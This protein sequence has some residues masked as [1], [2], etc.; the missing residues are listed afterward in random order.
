MW[1]WKCNL[2]S[3]APYTPVL[4]DRHM[5]AKLELLH[6]YWCFWY[7]LFISYQRATAMTG[8]RFAELII[9]NYLPLRWQTILLIKKYIHRKHCLHPTYKKNT[10]TGNIVCITTCHNKILLFLEIRFLIVSVLVFCQSLLQLVLYR[11]VIR[12]PTCAW[13]I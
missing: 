11:N 12:E 4:Q 1:R 6:F 5:S 10:Y 13:R 3:S 7:C 8:A 9:I 2:F